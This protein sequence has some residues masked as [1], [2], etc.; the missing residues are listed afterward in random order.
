MPR[1][2]KKSG[3]GAIADRANGSPCPSPKSVPFPKEG[4]RIETPDNQFCDFPYV[5]TVFS[6][7]Q[8]QTSGGCMSVT[9]S[10]LAAA[11]RGR[12][13]HSATRI[14]GT[15]LP[16]VCPDAASASFA[17]DV[18]PSVGILQKSKHKERKRDGMVA[19]L[20]TMLFQTLMFRGG[21]QTKH[22]Q[23]LGA[24]ACLEVAP[25]SRRRQLV[26]DVSASE[27]INR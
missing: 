15:D 19:R 6:K 18:E 14:A 17:T 11:E 25:S 10:T 27:T 21:N 12:V 16:L 13:S 1:S 9:A 4:D 20:S 23:R 8:H 26:R 5:L 3:S 2:R 22:M 7:R 24:P